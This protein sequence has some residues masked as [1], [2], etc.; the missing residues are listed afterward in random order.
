VTDAM[1]GQRHTRKRKPSAET[2]FIRSDGSD[3]CSSFSGLGD[4]AA[5]S[6]SK[7]AMLDRFLTRRRGQEPC[8]T[9]RAV[10]DDVSLQ[11]EKIAP[12]IEPWR[13]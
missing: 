6:F 3:L 2:G 7:M 10:M 11:L 12:H 5:E 1:N 13:V 8:C 9:H 4:C